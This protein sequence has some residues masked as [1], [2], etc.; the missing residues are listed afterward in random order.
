MSLN[1]KVEDEMKKIGKI[2]VI[3]LAGL[4][5]AGC[6]QKPKQKTSSKGSATIKVTK[7][8][9][10]PTK[11]GHLSDQDLSPQKNSSSCSCICW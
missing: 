6:S 5:L 9:K 3:L 4:A 1:W 7:N 11:M 2:S 10:Q 8:N